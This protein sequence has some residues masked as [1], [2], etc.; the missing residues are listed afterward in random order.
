MCISERSGV[1]ELGLEDL[2]DPKDKLWWKSKFIQSD[3][4]TEQESIFMLQ[5]M[6]Y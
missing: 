2:S 5:S 4:Y 3:V 1:E 6:R